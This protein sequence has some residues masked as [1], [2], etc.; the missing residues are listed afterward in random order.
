[1]VVVHRHVGADT[2]VIG[3]IPRHL[4]A[5]DIECSCSICLVNIYALNNG[6]LQKKFFYDVTP[7][8]RDNMILLG[9][10]NSVVETADRKSGQLD[11]T[12][13]ELASLLALWHLAEVSGSHQQAFSYHHPSIPERKS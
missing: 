7:Y 3:V 2:S 8:V 13:K 11:S 10:F 9:D 6:S 1:M 12:S 5:L 4:I